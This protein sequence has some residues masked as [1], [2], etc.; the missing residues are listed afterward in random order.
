M[1]LWKYLNKTIIEKKREIIKKIIK[2]LLCGRWSYFWL[3]HTA[4][5]SEKCGINFKWLQVWLHPSPQH[6]Q[7]LSILIITEPPTTT[8]DPP[9]STLSA[10]TFVWDH[11]DLATIVNT[12]TRPATMKVS[13]L[14]IWLIREQNLQILGAK[15]IFGEYRLGYSLFCFRI[16][17]LWIEVSK[18]TNASLKFK[19]RKI[20]WQCICELLKHEEKNNW[21]TRHQKSSC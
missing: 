20:T 15:N 8:T 6:L 3:W 17:S 5:S 10:N 4:L 19:Q 11:A 14:Q 21:A 12:C 2:Q 9:K 16:F 18:A 13:F 1:L 7:Q